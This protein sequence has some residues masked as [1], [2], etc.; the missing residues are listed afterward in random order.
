MYSTFILFNFILLRI[1]LNQSDQGYVRY[2]RLIIS[3]VLEMQFGK[4]RF[5]EKI[6][7]L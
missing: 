4:A 2:D 5:L 3:E 6:V 1:P 7:S